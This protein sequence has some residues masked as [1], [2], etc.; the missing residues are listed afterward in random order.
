[1]CSNYSNYLTSAICG[2]E[3]ACTGV[4]ASCI[5]ADSAAS[6]CKPLLSLKDIKLEPNFKY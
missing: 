5:I 2:T 1:M 3:E 6:N 4:G